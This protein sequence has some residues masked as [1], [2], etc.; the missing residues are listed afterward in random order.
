MLFLGL[1]AQDSI[2]Q[3]GF[4]TTYHYGF[5][6]PH[7]PLV[8]EI[9]KGH[10]QITELSFYKKTSGKRQWEQYFNFPKTGISAMII[11]SGNMESLGMIYGMFPYVEYPLNKWKVTWN[12]KFGYGVGYIQKPFDRVENYKNLA[13]GSHLNA[14]IFFNSLWSYN[15]TKNLNSSLGLSLTHFSNGSLKR[16]NLG[17]N[18]LSV[19]AGVGYEFGS[20]NPKVVFNNIDKE[21]KW[22]GS[23]ALSAGVKEI[24]PIGG[25]KYWVSSLSYSLLKTVTNKSSFGFGTDIFYNTSLDP[26]IQRV[27]FEDKGVMG[28]FR[29]GIN[30]TYG[31]SMGKL[32]LLFQ[33]G[34]YAY[35]AYEDNGYIYSKLVSRYQISDKLFANVALKTHFAVADFIEYGVGYRLH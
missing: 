28:N 31:L 19:N 33:V 11:H 2:P 10:T 16:P 35:T 21:K 32:D 9:I 17:I 29:L 13:I 14:L 18:L 34:G 3:F 30:G 25:R 6:A 5:I 26:L 1:K 24:P 20:M 4:K 23:V 8:N 22:E 7:K 27:Q 15:I 12:L